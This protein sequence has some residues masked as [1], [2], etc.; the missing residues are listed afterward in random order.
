VLNEHTAVPDFLII[1]TRLWNQLSPQERS[2]LQ[3]AVDES[4]IHQRE[5]WRASEEESLREVQAAGVQVIRPDKEPFRQ[6]V[7]SIYEM[8][9]RTDPELYGWVER[10]RSVDS[11]VDPD[12]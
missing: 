12:A 11:A 10:V 2:W 1:G 9:R 8:I 7:Q 4:V 5:L 6:Q 3:Q